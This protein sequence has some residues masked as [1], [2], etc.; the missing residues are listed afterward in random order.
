MYNIT[1]D[2]P[3]LNGDTVNYQSYDMIE[4]T[5]KYDFNEEAAQNYLEFTEEQLINRICEF[6]SRI[7]QVHPFQEGNTRTTAIFIQKYLNSIGFKVNN[8]LF[9]N[10]SQYFRNALV[11]ANYTNYSKGISADNKFLK[12]FFEN[13]LLY[14]NNELNND[15]LKI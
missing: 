4:E 13:L 6:T 3:I 9:K 2:E 15:D 5:L 12:M 1:K 14:K 10:N 7:W 8:E 11:R